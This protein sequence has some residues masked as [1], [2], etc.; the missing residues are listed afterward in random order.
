MLVFNK[1]LQ[2]LRIIMLSLNEIPGSVVVEHARAS[3]TPYRNQRFKQLL[4]AS[5]V[6]D[7]TNRHDES[8]QAE[9]RRQ[10]VH[11]KLLLE[12]AHDARADGELPS[13]TCDHS[14][15]VPVHDQTSLNKRN[16]AVDASGC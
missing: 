16:Q 12:V 13:T 4:D 9:S 5:N 2:N 10:R 8:V 6:K 11:D 1:P 7:E 14:M 15:R 3:K